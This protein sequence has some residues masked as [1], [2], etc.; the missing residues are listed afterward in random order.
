MSWDSFNRPWTDMCHILNSPSYNVLLDLTNFGT[1]D[2]IA[3]P[4]DLTCI[5]LRS[6]VFGLQSDGRWHYGRH[7]EDEQPEMWVLLWLIKSRVC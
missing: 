3:K 1:L 2:Y 4:A 7:A 6:G 5:I